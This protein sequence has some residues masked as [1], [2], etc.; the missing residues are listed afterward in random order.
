M[1]IRHDHTCVY[2]LSTVLKPAA[3][4]CVIKPPLSFCLGYTLNSKDEEVAALSRRLDSEVG[5]A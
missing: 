5:C 3:M 1:K 2:V 4:M